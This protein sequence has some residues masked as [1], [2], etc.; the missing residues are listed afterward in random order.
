MGPGF[1]KTVGDFIRIKHEVN[2]L[3]DL[4]RQVDPT[5]AAAD[6]ATGH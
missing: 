3:D 2:G 5:A 6:D 1:R 4:I